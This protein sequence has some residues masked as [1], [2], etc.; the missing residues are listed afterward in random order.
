MSVAFWRSG[1]IAE[2]AGFPCQGC[3]YPPPCEALHC[4]S[5][6]QPRKTSSPGAVAFKHCQS[7]H[8]NPHRG[9]NSATVMMTQP[10]LYLEALD[11]VPCP[12]PSRSD[13]R[14]PEHLG[15]WFKG[16]SSQRMRVKSTFLTVCFLLRRVPIC[17]RVLLQSQSPSTLLYDAILKIGNSFIKF[18]RCGRGKRENQLKSGFSALC[19][20]YAYKGTFPWDYTLGM[21]RIYQI[22]PVNGE[23][24]PMTQLLGTLRNNSLHLLSRFLCQSWK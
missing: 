11:S 15:L 14:F 3:C 9:A 8:F 16:S 4:L 22:L 10:E 17:W 6:L 5:L 13:R 21:L 1:G 18:I 19:M 23:T 2:A 12:S 20:D 7:S 24:Q